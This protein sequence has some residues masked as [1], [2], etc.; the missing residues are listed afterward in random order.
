MK[1]IFDLL[2]RLASLLYQKKFIV[3]GAVDEY[4]LPVQLLDEVIAYM[5]TM[6]SNPQ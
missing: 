4:V 6:L 2:A 5:N 1:R 3:G